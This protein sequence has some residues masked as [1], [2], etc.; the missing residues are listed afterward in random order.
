MPDDLKSLATWKVRE[1]AATVLLRYT[2]AY[3][4]AHPYTPWGAPG[5]TD[6]EA[7]RETLFSAGPSTK[8]NAAQTAAIG[9]GI[10]LHL[11][12]EILD[13]L[14][15][16]LDGNDNPAS[17]EAVVLVA[18]M[19]S[20]LEKMLIVGSYFPPAHWYSPLT[21][22]PDYWKLGP[23]FKCKPARADAP[24]T[25]GSASLEIDFTA[26]YPNGFDQDNKLA[27]VATFNLQ[28]LCYEGGY[29]RASLLAACVGK[30]T[31]DSAVPGTAD[32][33]ALIDL[34]TKPPA[35]SAICPAN[36]IV[37]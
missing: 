4:V 29:L 33:V 30:L 8:F 14:N 28:Q 23:S 18:S 11:L 35:G 3:I 20:L 25:P 21:Q 7:A 27:P 12:Q 31:V 22:A 6:K 10:P 26:D 32:L 2:L 36:P 1:V 5:I 19:V 15:L 9:V 24:L 17:Y 16:K 13:G 34:I 37:P